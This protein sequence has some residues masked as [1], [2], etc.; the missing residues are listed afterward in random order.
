MFKFLLLVALVPVVM[1][2]NADNL[3]HQKWSAAT[4]RKC[5]AGQPLPHAVRIENC[6]GDVCELGRGT[7]ANMAMDFTANQE[8]TSLKSKATAYLLGL[9]VPYELP[10][11]IA[12]A[13]TW[14]DGTRC[15]VSEGEDSTYV[16][17]FPMG[18]YPAISLEVEFDVVNQNG[19]SQ[20]CFGIK[21]QVV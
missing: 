3:P 12:N 5:K 2:Q 14:L 13:C 11:D 10:A 18:D 16:L 8:C 6:P 19:K 20:G 9:P 7:S 15:P 4:V 17:K 21:V 1:L